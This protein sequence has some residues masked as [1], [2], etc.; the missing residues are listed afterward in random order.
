MKQFKFKK[1]LLILI[2]VAMPGLLIAQKKPDYSGTWIQDNQKSDEYYRSFNVTLTITQ[3]EKSISFREVFSDKAGK[4]MATRE[5]SFNL[6]GKEIS[7]EA[8]GGIDKSV[9]TW[10]VD[11]KTLNT[12]NTSVTGS[13]VYGSKADYSL[14][15]D[16]KVL[17]VVVSDIK[18]GGLVVKQVFNRK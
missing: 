8:H 7:V 12:K 17:T 1:A 5:Y 18:P 6:D 10:S 13:D 14:S 2:C 4:D 15:A 3:T 11:N 16:G 9:A